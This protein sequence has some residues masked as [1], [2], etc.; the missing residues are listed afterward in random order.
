MIEYLK[1][2]IEQNKENMWL[3]RCENDNEIRLGVSNKINAINIAENIEEKFG[4][5]VNCEY[6]WYEK[7]T[8]LQ[9][10][11]FCFIIIEEA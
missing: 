2:L 4:I 6:R 3:V 10:P 7:E 5:E 11:D 9:K 1:N 8:E